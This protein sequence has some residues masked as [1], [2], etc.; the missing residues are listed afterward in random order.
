M[1]LALGQTIFAAPNKPGH[2]KVG[3]VT[4]TTAVVHWGASEVE[5]GARVFYDI[6]LRRRI[7]GK[8]T[9]WDHVA[10]T[11]K[12]E[13][14]VGH[15]EPGT[16]YEVRVR[17]WVSKKP[18]EWRIKEHAFTTLSGDGDHDEGEH[19]GDAKP[20]DGEDGEGHGE[21]EGDGK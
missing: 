4:A 2:I 7:E 11:A 3:K 16:V 20:S 15:L 19:G 9:D 13:V 14:A 18:S 5:E 1:L 8:P 17:G 10:E 12:T 21:G 6:Q